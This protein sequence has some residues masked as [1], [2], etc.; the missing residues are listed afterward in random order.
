MELKADF[1]ARAQNQPPSSDERA[2]IGS[3]G[4]P[5]K[6]AFAGFH[7]V[8]NLTYFVAAIGFGMFFMHP[9]SLAVSLVCAAG[10]AVYLHG[11][12]AVRVG[13]AFLLPIALLTA[14]LNPLFNH[15][16]VTILAYLPNGNPLTLEAV[17]YGIAA[18][19]MLTAVIAW[20]ACWNAV[21]TSDKFVYLFGRA[22]PALSLVLSMSLRF[23]PRFRAQLKVIAAAQKGIGHDPAGGGL[24]QKIRGGARILSAL[25]TWALENAIETADSMKAR[26]YGLPGRTAFSIFRFERRDALAL[27][28]LAGCACIVIVGTATGAYHFRYFPSVRGQWAGA[29]TLAVFAAHFALC[30]LPL[31]LNLKEE[32][33]WKRIESRI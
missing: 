19:V 11:R 1:W 3:G 14:V 20:F 21:M 17:L 26:G 32:L 2:R 29:G 33:L 8:V 24:A 23:I 18:A 13:L 5:V 28:Y 6:D 7:P 22:A 12:K 30:A 16:G 27:A 25:V 31:A 15:A 10:Y 9:V 4:S